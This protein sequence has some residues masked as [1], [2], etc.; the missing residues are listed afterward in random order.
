MRDTESQRLRAAVIGSGF[1]GMAAAIRLQTAGVQ[2]VLFEAHDQPG[3]RARVFREGPWVFD[4]GPT[5]ITAPHTLEELF[6]LSGRKLADEVEL[7]PVDPLYRLY[8]EDGDRFDYV[9]DHE[10]M[11]AQIRARNPADVEGYERFVRYAGEV[12]EAGYRELATTPFL[13]FRDMVRVAPQLARLR[14]DRSVYSTVARYVK[15]DHLRQALSFHSLLV[16]G[17]PYQT[18]SIYTLIHHLEREWGVFFPRGG[19][20]ALVQGLVRHFEALGGE[21]RLAS[22][23]GQVRVTQVAGRPVHRIDSATG[24]DEPFDLVV[25]NADIHHTY[26]RLYR[27]DVRAQRRTRKLESMDWSMGLF[28]L[29]FGTDRPY[30]EEIAHHNVLFGPRYKGL[31]DEIFHGHKLPDDFSLYLHAPTHSDPS[32]GPA[33]GG[34]FYVLSPVPHLGHA[35]IDWRH[36]GERYAEKLL[37]HLERWMPD[38]RAHVQV[39]RWMTPEDFQGELHALHGS[40]FSCAPRLTQSAWFR[41]HNRDDEIPGLYIVGAGTHPGAGVPGVISSAKAT[42]SIIAEDFGLPEVDLTVVGEMQARLR[43]PAPS[44]GRRRPTRATAPRPGE[45][46]A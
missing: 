6:S 11:L 22:P 15:D 37:T 35:P 29:Y 8:W 33:G 28:V 45:E 44:L 36:E 42:L 21:L 10:G 30:T 7:L 12:F 2:T 19:T 43:A 31:L 32:L 38:L 27:Q 40:A 34:T 24:R 20:G 4:A 46:A 1:G 17:N 13:N 16:G 41:P 14:A 26:S 25:S 39:K 9:G 18:S 23:V 5:V 3:G